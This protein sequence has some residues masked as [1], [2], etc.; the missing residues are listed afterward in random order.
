MLKITTIRESD[1]TIIKLEGR[2]A[3]P[4]IE[5]LER[6]WNEVVQYGSMA[7]DLSDV[8]FV[9]S[10]GRQLL[11]SM[12]GQGVELRSRS[13]LTQFI[14]GQIKNTSNGDCSTRDGGSSGIT[15]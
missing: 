9:S 14:I 5:E 6:V 10:E 3:G 2:L 11:K 13:L 1:T 4:W 7:I 12:H 8:T 15:R